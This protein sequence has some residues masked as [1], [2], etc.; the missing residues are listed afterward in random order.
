[1]SKSTS[2][3]GANPADVESIEAIIAAAYRLISGDAGEKRNWDR[4]RSLFAPGARL[5][6]TSKQAGVRVPDGQT[7]DPLDVERYISRVTEYFDQ[8]GFFETEVA[9]RTEQYDH[10]AHAFSTYESRHRADD[11]EP[12]MRG[13]NSFQLY[14]DGK[15]W[16]IVTIYWQQ[17]NPD[18]PIP[19]EYL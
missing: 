2:E 11:V 14:H 17:E 1:M 3:T 5:I 6:P 12:F 9:R 19:D 7:P 8:N 10:V 15:R 13:I 16:W 4:V 18:C